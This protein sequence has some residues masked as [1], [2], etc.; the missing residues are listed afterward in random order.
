MTNRKM[1]SFR[2]IRYLSY[3]LL[4]R[5]KKGHRIH[6]PFIYDLVSRVFRNKIDPATIMAIEEIRGKMITD[7]RSILVKDLGSRESSL[8]TNFRRV[9]DLARYSPVSR[10]Y[11]KLLSNL[12]AEF[13]K[14]LI[15]ELGT[16]LGISTMY[17]A[18]S[19]KEAIVCTIEGCP[20]T[21]A[22]ARQNFIDAGLNN[23]NML[24]GPF[25][26][27]LPVLVASDEKPGLVFIDG[28]H[29][30][31]PVINYFNQIAELSDYKTVIIVD[32]INYSKEMAEAWDEL[33]L[34][35]K[36]SVSIDLFRMGILFFREGINH[37]NYI[38]RY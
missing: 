6:S 33:K 27:V 18:A 23:I 14:P 13:G 37:N 29:R 10:K 30:K 11:G 1:I 9:S 19:C 5:H 38:I 34:H 17:M 31:A 26:E 28:N 21:A 36:V 2:A 24:E 8:K 16:S 20:E 22:I 15:I 12:A 25:D 7:K 35:K 32:D 4:S 3:I